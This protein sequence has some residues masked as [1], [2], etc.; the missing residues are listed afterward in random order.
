MFVRAQGYTL[1][2][3]MITLAIISILAAISLP[4]YMQYASS[5]ANNA[6]LGEVKGYTQS[7]M[8]AIA[9]GNGAPS[10]P[11]LGAC[12]W[13]TNASTIANLSSSTIL[14]AFPQAP[15][16]VGSRCNMNSSAICVLEPG[17]S[18]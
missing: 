3:L 7:V 10:A 12:R 1:I 13:I 9:E 14:E 6:C 8:V 5:A 18:P 2:E 15:G 11:D 4:A 16:D 17:V